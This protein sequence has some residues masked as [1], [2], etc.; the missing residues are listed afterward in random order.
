MAT[1]WR[2]ASSS[3]TP[4][5]SWESRSFRPYTRRRSCPSWSVASASSGLKSLKV[6]PNYYQKPIDDPGYFPAFEWC[7]DRGVTIMS[8]SSAG[9]GDND[10]TEPRR[11]V[12]LAERYPNINW[13][14]AHSGN[15][16]MGQEQAVEAA[17]ACP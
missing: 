17:R 16:R 3:G 14:L 2:P 1:R 12:P 5:A 15:A 4:T 8:H 6:Y 10:L 9:S 11:F 13:V 7:N